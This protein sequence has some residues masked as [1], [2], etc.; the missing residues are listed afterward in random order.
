MSER[1]NLV[2][3]FRE[4]D[5]SVVAFGDEVAE[6]VG[7]VLEPYRAG[8]A[9]WFERFRSNVD[10]S[11]DEGVPALVDALEQM[12]IIESD[13]EPAKRVI[14]SAALARANPQTFLPPPGDTQLDDVTLLV[15]VLRP[16]M[17]P[18]NQTPEK[19]FELLRLLAGKDENG[20]DD[21]KLKY[22][23]QATLAVAVERQLLEAGVAH[24][25]AQCCQGT[26][27]SV[28]V[29]GEEW[30]ASVLT[31]SFST[32]EI[33]LNELR[34]YLSPENWPDC[35]TLWCSMDR[36]NHGLSPPCYLEH[37]SFTCPG[38]WHL[39]TCLEFVRSGPRE[40]DQSRVPALPGSD[41]PPCVGPGRS[42]RRGVHRRRP[43]RLSGAYYV[44]QAG[45][46]QRPVRRA[47][48][49][50]VVVRPRLW[51]GSPGD[52]VPLFP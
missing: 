51:R 27:T 14:A 28:E 9:G 21:P 19:G 3:L 38:P 15:E 46:V 7:V 34:E 13:I 26:W 17:H 45:V 30:L 23:W 49:R 1:A 43:E 6:D 37:I 52:G 47:V 40:R 35:C 8:A 42:G 22:D 50:H 36:L 33:D 12:T 4:V 10:E 24:E 31:T 48:V 16:A 25:A 29:E 39:L 2:S 41:P 20:N 44:D 11:F 18:D 5:R 32:A